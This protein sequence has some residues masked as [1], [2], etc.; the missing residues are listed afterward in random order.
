M[1]ESRLFIERVIDYQ[2]M[3]VIFTEDLIHTL[4]QG[5]FQMD[6]PKA[7]A[8]A[9]STEGIGNPHDLGGF[10]KE[11]LDSAFN[12]LRPRPRV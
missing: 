9:L 6:F 1:I 3:D 8:D 10:P 11:G 12:N 7:T 2:T 5:D 4:F